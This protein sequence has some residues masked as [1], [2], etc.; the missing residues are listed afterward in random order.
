MPDENGI[1]GE[2][3]R[4]RTDGNGKA[5]EQAGGIIRV[6]WLGRSRWGFLSMN[7]EDSESERQKN[8]SGQ[9][10]EILDPR[11]RSRKPQICEFPCTPVG[12]DAGEEV[13]CWSMWVVRFLLLVL[14]F[15][16]ASS[17]HAAK[18]L[19]FDRVFI[20][21]EKFDALLVQAQKKNWKRLPIGER[22]AAVGRALTG[23]PYKSYT[24]EIDDT[25]EAPSVNF[26]GLDC[27]TFFEVS[28]AFARM[29]DDDP[30]HWTPRRMLYYIELDR[31][32]SGRCD[33]TYT[34]RL[35][36]L[37][38][39]IADNEERGLIKDLTRE[40]GGVRVPHQAREMTVGW[41]HYR[42]MRNSAAVR[43]AIAAMERRV[44]AMP[45]YHIPKSKVPGIEKKL[46]NGDIICITSR[47][48]SK[49]ATSHVGL[50]V[51]DSK[52]VLRFMHASSPRNYG[53]VVIDQRLSG[54]LNEFSSHAG[55]MV[56]R[57]LK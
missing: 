34:S 53:K 17:V 32:R 5:G 23:T 48:G 47:D 9:H 7:S 37:E 15:F 52:G 30:E 24:L 46:R 25:I 39:W 10:G 35:H 2:D 3:F 44:S 36:Y 29:L 12:R 51:R 20:G 22:T 18:S 56:A 27:W 41:K 50:A 40:L 28:L 43:A 42:Y 38:D 57:P 55:I 16:V 6:D 26:R 33:G 54:Y 14:A 11:V 8:D 31:Y 49:I 1:T 13:R 21:K 19:P 4:G 45:M